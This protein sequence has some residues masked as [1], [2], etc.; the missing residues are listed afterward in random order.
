VG[1]DQA[2]L[3]QPEPLAP[4]HRLDGFACGKPPLDQ[5]L[6]AHALANE[7]KA[8]RTFV[9]CDDARNVMAY[10]TL[11]TGSVAR[12]QL[13]RRIR[14]DVPNPVPVM[15]LGR[16][17]VDRRCQGL[18]LGAALLREAML[19][20]LRVSAQAGVRALLVHAIDDQALAFY[21]RY[22]FQAFPQETRTLLLPIETIA[23]AIP[24][25]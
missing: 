9:V 13:P 11:A 12:T 4:H 8:S 2:R 16:L 17:A 23:A 21:T 14:H 15:V 1:I 20:T 10:Y 5:W 24:T 25:D 22:G 3:R 6:R 18:Q 19:R 7:G